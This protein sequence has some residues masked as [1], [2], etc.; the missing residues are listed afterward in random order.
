MPRSGR[1]GA[2]HQ[3]NRQIAH[4]AK[5]QAKKRAQIRHRG[6]KAVGKIRYGNAQ[7]T[8]AQR[9]PCSK[10]HQRQHGYGQ[11]DGAVVVRVKKQDQP[12]GKDHAEQAV[13]YGDHEPAPEAAPLALMRKGHTAAD[14]RQRTGVTRLQKSGRTIGSEQYLYCREQLTEQPCAHPEQHRAEKQ[15][16]L[17][18][19][20]D[21]HQP[22]NLPRRP[23][24]TGALSR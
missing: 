5:G 13:E 19:G 11:A 2:D 17:Q 23:F 9:T 24:L 22:R 4:A 14:E 18:G 20:I 7:K 3:A 21:L 8:I 1:D 16:R 6:G 15:S 10:A 12:Q